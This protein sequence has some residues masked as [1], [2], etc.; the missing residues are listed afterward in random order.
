MKSKALF[1]LSCFGI[2]NLYSDSI[3]QLSSYP[4]FCKL[5]AQNEKVFSGFK[6]NPTYQ[7]ILEHVTYDQGNEY[8]KIIEAES[9]IIFQSLEKYKLN[10]RLG[11]PNVYA[12]GSLYGDFSPTTLRY[13]K[14]AGDLLNLFGNLG[15]MNIVEIGGGYGGQCYILSAAA[16]F[17]TYTIVDL[18]EVALLQKKYL[19][20]LGVKNVECTDYNKFMPSKSYDLV[21]SNYAFTEVT[22]DGQLQYIEQIIN[23]SKNGY[24]TCN[25]VSSGFGLNSLD[26]QELIGL[27]SLPNRLVEIISER[28]LTHPRNV[29][30]I[31]REK[32]I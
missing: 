28:P 6:R 1:L 2:F 3:S 16:G 9:P 25:F 30:V 32:G 14:V 11:M 17:K 21:I 22:K 13:M 12:Y 31:W 4:F 29:I 24:L 27:I 5:A 15:Q 26:L 23:R 19:A 18:P 8:L 20:T 7:L 10:D